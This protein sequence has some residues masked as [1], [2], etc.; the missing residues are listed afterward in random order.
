MDILERNFAKSINSNIMKIGLYD[1]YDY[2]N[3]IISNSEF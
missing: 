2:Y 1:N 3:I